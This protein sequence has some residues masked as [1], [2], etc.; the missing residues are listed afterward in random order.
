MATAQR[1]R[2]S[3]EEREAVDRYLSLMQTD[4]ASESV[5]V[6]PDFLI[7]DGNADL[8]FLHYFP[9]DFIN[10]EPLNSALLNMLENQ[11]RTVAWCPGGHG[12]STTLRHWFPYVIAR[13][14]QISMIYIEKNDTTAKQAARALMSILENNDQL[15]NDFGPF[16]GDQWS[17]EAITIANRPEISQWPTLSFY[18]A[19]GSS[20]LGKRCNICVVDDPVTSDN[21]NSILERARLL[22]W[23]NEQPGTAPSPLPISNTRYLNKLFLVGTT[24]HMDDLFHKVLQGGGFEHLWLKAVNGAGDCLAPTRFCYRDPDEL[25]ESAETNPADTRL[26][27][28]IKSG[29]VTNLCTWRKHHGTAA[30]LKRYQ[31]EI[32]D[33]DSQRFP[34]IWFDGGRDELSPPSG[35][36]G[37]LE[38]AVSLGAERKEGW[39]YVTGVDPAA[40]TQGPKTVRFACVTLGCDLK[41][42]QN[43]VHL[44]D[45]DFGQQPMVSDNPA[46]ESQVDIVL[47]H[48]ARY[49]SKLVLETNNVQGV[50]A[51][52]IRKEARE[53]G[54]MVNIIGH[55]TTRA[56]KSDEELGI[57]AMAPMV[58]NGYLRL[59]YL[60]P[61]TQKKIEALI[62]EMV[63]WQKMDTDDILMA[64]WFAWRVLERGKRASIHMRAEELEPSPVMMTG[65]RWDYP[66]SWTQQDIDIFHGRIGEEE[67]YEQVC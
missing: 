63:F 15:R 25:K 18:G 16:K 51:Q 45:L 53:R 1:V 57:E 38:L 27:E 8:F 9:R 59:P 14:P 43:T 11:N 67:A 52:V 5:S 30:F 24:F 56:K 55:F 65:D 50:W 35:Y 47:D 22:Q 4:G 20:V 12:K 39:T 62:D 66:P 3:E 2:L 36:P 42:D 26:M 58:E 48:I 19:G 31:N 10:W 49:G 44:V 6:D 40:G 41:N 17:T 32:M 21:S 37:C 23:F 64:L 33:P 60:K 61:G 13:E 29:E 46:R 7:Q 54:Q 28:R 34:R